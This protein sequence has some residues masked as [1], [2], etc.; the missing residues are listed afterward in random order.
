MAAPTIEDVQEYGSAQQRIANDIINLANE[1]D[2]YGDKY[3]ALEKADLIAR[4]QQR[5]ADVAVLPDAASFAG[6]RRS[7]PAV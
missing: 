5:L 7:P 6:K 4:I 3:K 1:M 2:R